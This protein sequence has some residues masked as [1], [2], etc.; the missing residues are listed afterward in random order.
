MTVRKKILITGSCGFIFSNFIRIALKESWPYQIISIDK[1]SRSENIYNVYANRSHKFYLGDITD[2]HL[3]NTIFELEKPDIVLHGAAESN[4]DDAISSTNPFIMSNVL[5]TQN[6]LDASVKYDVK[7]FLYISTDEVLGH[8]DENDKSWTEESFLNPRNPYSASK[9]AGELLVKAANVTYGLP[10][11][12]TRTCNNF[13]PKQSVK[14]LIPKT[15]YSIL[16]KNK[17]PIYGQGKQIREWIH[18]VDNCE[19]I[20]TVLEKGRINEIYNIGTGFETSNLELVNDICNIMNEGYDLISFIK[21]PRPGHDFRY[22]LDSSKIRSLGW[23]PKFRFKDG[24]KHTIK[25]YS[26]NQNWFCRN[27]HKNI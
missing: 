2:K 20:R 27:T 23:K 18:V 6:L 12:I 22:S 4:V 24:L 17:I 19:A 10:F 15:I 7:Q 9:A 14:N 5:G 8:L 16:E 25:W 3:I 11:N 21:D 13:G 26:N 1:V